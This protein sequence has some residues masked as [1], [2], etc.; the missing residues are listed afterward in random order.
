MTIQEMHY[1]FKLKYDRVNSSS[2]EDFNPAEIDWFLNRAQD[3]VVR[4]RYS[5]NNPNRTSF[6][7]NQKR[8]DDLKAIHIKFPD[9][10]LVDL[11][12]HGGIYELE[13]SSLK[14][15]YWFLTNASVT[16]INDDCKTRVKLKSMQS[17][18][19]EELIRDPFDK[20][21]NSSV[22]YN[23]GKG[24]NGGSS[25][26]IYSGDL[27]LNQCR[28]EYLKKPVRMT[29]GGYT[30]I[31]GTDSTI[32]NCE[33]SDHIHPEIVDA[34]VFLAM[35]SIGDSQVSLSAQKL[36]INE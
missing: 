15:E 25:I 23:F 7:Q 2:K 31:D 5:G 26:Y 21:S 36:S 22:P 35:S 4:T 18:D 33:L 19:Y 10:P 28:I 14:Y 17:D 27:L 3:L 29:I 20:P 9:Q 1:D 8:I 24:T 16:L 13:L 12:N 34:A 6:E 32:T 30:Y 11:I